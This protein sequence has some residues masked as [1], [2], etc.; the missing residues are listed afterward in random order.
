M[1]VMVQQPQC[2]GGGSSA[3]LLWPL[4]DADNYYLCTPGSMTM[5]PLDIV[6]R[7]PR[8]QGLTGS[9]LGL[10]TDQVSDH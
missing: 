3:P 7:L 9:D 6:T 1:L 8:D 4:M 2:V 5:L 10:D